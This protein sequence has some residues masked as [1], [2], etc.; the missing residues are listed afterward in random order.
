MRIYKLISF[1]STAISL[2][3]PLTSFAEWQR[4]DTTLAWRSGDRL[5]W[6]LSYEPAKGK[7]FSDPL[8][9]SSGTSLTKVLSPEL[10]WH[11]GLWFSWKF[12]NGVNYWEEDRQS[13]KS[14]GSTRWSP[15]QIE[16]HADGSALIQFTAT[17]THP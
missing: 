7:P 17:Y 14:E 1:A 8:T 12:I 16:T 6:P 15:P 4:D 13:G 2:L 5:L 3:A 10:P 11:Y 9:T